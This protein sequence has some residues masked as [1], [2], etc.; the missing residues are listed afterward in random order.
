M[1]KIMSPRIYM[2]QRLHEPVGFAFTSEEARDFILDEKNP[3]EYSVVQ[4]S[5][6]PQNILILDSEVDYLIHRGEMKC[7]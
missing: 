2:I 1:K 5:R 6:I 4:V 7:D 3:S